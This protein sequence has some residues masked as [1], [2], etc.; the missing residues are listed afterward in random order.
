MISKVITHD[1]IFHAD[2][3]M[4]VALLQEFIRPTIQIERTRNI[5]SDEF[6]NPDIWIVDV[7]GQYDQ[8]NNNYDHHQDSNLHSACVLV[9]KELI[10]R[11][12]MDGVV[13]E[14]LIDNLLEIS[15]IDCN[16]PADKN[17][18]QVNSLI[19]SFNAIDDGFDIAV[20]VC[21]N[22][23]KAC[24]A[25]VAKAEESRDIWDR[26]EKIGLIRVCDSFPVHWKKSA[27]F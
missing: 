10:E 18:F 24:K 19:K 9:C 1:G 21:R 3:V 14:E 13:Y 26:G 6:S 2:D 17:G 7:G 27:I 23:I 16:G 25:N 15:E 5:S 20:K 8:V 4:S 22:Y 12:F 11:G